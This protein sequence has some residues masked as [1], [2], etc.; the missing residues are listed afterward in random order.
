MRKL[1]TSE[2]ID[3]VNTLAEA[4]RQEAGD[5]V[6]DP[7][8]KKYLE[9]IKTDVAKLESTHSIILANNKNNDILEADRVRDRAL[10]AFR[11]LMQVYELSEDGSPEAQ[12][13]EELNAWWLNKYDPLPYMSL[14]VETTGIEDL[15]LDLSVN[16]YAQ[17]IQTLG[18][19]N[20]VEK[21]RQTAEA[22]KQVYEHTMNE[23]D[24][25][26]NYDARTLRMELIDTIQRYND[27][28][29]ALCDS[30]DNKEIEALKR[31]LR[32]VQHKFRDQTSTRHAG[33][34]LLPNSPAK[35]ES[36]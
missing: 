33:V 28:V 4:T 36:A 32:A 6:S 35:D 8:A 7:I 1:T 2:L 11:R 26:P 17:H 24:M 25:K 27:Y 12:A 22:F 23:N 20:A 34:A 3:F 14:N 31:A 5:F 9:T 13:Y 21:I 18:L 15:L 30:S 29:T 16:R 10:S 19:T